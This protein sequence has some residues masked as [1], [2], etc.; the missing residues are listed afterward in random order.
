MRIKVTKLDVVLLGFLGLIALAILWPIGIDH[1]TVAQKA[2]SKAQFIGYTNALQQYRTMYGDYPT[3]FDEN[4]PFNLS[5]GD[6]S[7]KF[8][9][10]LTGRDAESKPVMSFGNRKS[11]PFYSFADDAYL[12]DKE[13]GQ[14]QIVDAY[15]NPNIVIL[16]DH[17]DDGIIMAPADGK[18][19][20]V[21]AKFV[22][23]TLPLR[24]KNHVSV[25]N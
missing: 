22:I 16:V 20:E 3:F 6:N 10:A 13:S 14:R 11:V 21:E 7:E 25:L 18:L 17:D 9:E 23:Y 2:R 8:I 12:I 4:G 5:E 19:Q 15:G 1:G 24:D